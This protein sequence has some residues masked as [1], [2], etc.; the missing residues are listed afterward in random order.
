[1]KVAMKTED[2][3]SWELAMDEE[4]NAL[5]NNDIWFLVSFLDE[6]KPT[7]CKQVS[8]YKFNLD[9]NVKKY[10][11]MF[12]IKIYSQVKVTYFGEIF[13]LVSKLRYVSFLLSIVATFDLEVEQMDAKTMFLH[14][15]LKEDIYMTQ[16]KHYLEKR[17]ES[18]V[19]ELPKSLYVP[20]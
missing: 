1:M 8:K 3:E 10:K 19:C 11:A 6:R 20:K 17:K 12:I 18:L 7:S 4:T 16:P 2:K 13:S 15:D 9:N 5:R 14:G